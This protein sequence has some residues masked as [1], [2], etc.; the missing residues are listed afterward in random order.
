M[1]SD[2]N[3]T[4][5]SLEN[6]LQVLTTAALEDES[7]RK[8]LL[9]VVM[10]AVAELEAPIETIWRIIMSPHAPAALMV[11]IRMGIV[12]H[13]A[14]TGVPKSA[15]EL[16]A[17]CGGSELVIVRMMRPL[18]A[19]GIFRETEV[20]TYASTPISELLVAPPLL[21]GYQFMFA[22]ATH[23]LANMPAYLESTGFKHVDGAPGPFQATK[24]TQDGMFQWLAK[25]PAMMSNFNAF[26]AGSL[27]T[28]SD[29]FKTFPVNEILLDGATTRDSESTL[30]VDIGGGEGHD[31]YA[32]HKSFPDAPG[33]LVLQDLPET[34]D[35]IKS[36][37]SAIIRQKY[38]FFT[39][40]PV[41]GARAYYL[42][43]IFHDWPD[44]DCI[45][46]MKNIAAAMKPG[47]S[48][49]L[50]FEWVLPAKET[51]LYP[52]LLDVNMMALLNGMERTEEQWTNLLTQAGLKIKKVWSAGIDSEG[53]IEAVLDV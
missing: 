27:E 11:L 43:Y 14:K 29:W 33:K 8:K 38:N 51:P 40:Q 37:D 7:S 12:T 20:Q 49:L 44:K 21:G 36:L 30:L 26:M 35:N 31:I 9:G 25:D 23:S 46:I 52:A 10:K 45:S 5:D 34:I 22:A 16:A 42:R 19:L 50:I 24:N 18:V 17:S 39:E 6:Q 48:K 2:L 47:Y 13:L 3:N 32:F 15:S 1:A 4:I 41:K 28:R 53:L